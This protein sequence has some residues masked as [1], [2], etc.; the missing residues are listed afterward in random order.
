MTHQTLVPTVNHYDPEDGWTKTTC[1]YCGVGCGVEV[2]ARA[3][4]RVLD[5]RGDQSHPANYGRLCSKGLA[6]GETVGEEG[7]LLHPSIEGVRTSWP[8]ALSH[9]ADQFN[10]VIRQHGAESVA[11]Y[12]SG[13]LLTEDYYVANKLMKGFIG[14][15]NIDTNSRLCMSS[16]VAGHKRAFGSDTVPGCYEDLEQADMLVLTG[17]NLA[18]CHPVL[19]QRI[20]AVKQQRPDFKIVVIDPRRTDTCDLADLHLAIAPGTDVALFNGLLAHLAQHGIVDEDY[21]QSHTEGF[22]EALVTAMGHASNRRTLATRLGVDDHQLETFFQWFAD[23]PKVVTVYSQGVNQSSAGTDKV[24]SIINC[25]LATGRIGQPGSGPFS[26]TGQPNAMGGREV[27]GLATTLA[28]HMEFDNREHVQLVQDF[29]GS[30]RLARGPGLKAVDMFDAIESGKIKAVWIM[31]TNPAMSLPNADKVRR[32]LEKC[33][34]VVVSDCMADTDTARLANV[35]LPATGW[36]EKSGT[37][38]NSERR[39]SRQRAALPALGEA[40]PD[41]WII[42]QVAQR[43]GFSEAF[44]Y[45]SEA[46]IFREYVALTAYRNDGT[47]N[48]DLSF[49]QGLTDAEYQQMLPRQW[50]VRKGADIGRNAKRLFGDGVFSTPSGRANFVTV[51]HR[52]PKTQVD[53]EYPLVLNTGR[54]RD[55]WHSMTRTGLSARLSG[56]S[57]EPFVNI[58]AQDAARYQLQDGALADVTSHWGSVR[59][60]VQVSDQCQKGQIFMPMHWNDVFAS[61]ARVCALIGENLDPISGQP[62]NKFTPVKVSPWQGKSEAILVMR[63]RR[64][65]LDCDYWAAQPIEGGTLYHIA[66]R[67]SPAELDAYLQSLCPGSAESAQHLTFGHPEQGEFRHAVLRQQQL[68]AAYALAKSFGDK[69]FSWLGQLLTPALDGGALG[70]LFKGEPSASL[71]GGRLVCACKQVGY[72]T[73]CDAIRTQNLGSVSELC[74]VTQA[75]TG[76]GSCLPELEQIVAEEKADATAA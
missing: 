43:M 2:K 38:T 52:P 4:S 63:D 31:A 60:R 3:N 18:W 9:V 42:T 68:L 17:S 23:T 71:A 8:E 51:S 22:T 36:A 28:A 57:P 39:I 15:G 55:Q 19:Y 21:I 48:L 69:E 54:I 24:N 32:A 58:G 65:D 66:S 62:E 46:D 53:S 1:A 70:A 49:Y 6:L 5:V 45:Q 34:L 47:R 74:A 33:P 20:K 50:P 72:K 61:K 13:Q 16:S 75:G 35:L 64:P 26:V 27:G 40:R 37:V 73:L 67:R 56:H 10:E 44:G 7:R 11:F 29:W 14:S 59:V 12:V 41:W 76:C 30:E 25:H